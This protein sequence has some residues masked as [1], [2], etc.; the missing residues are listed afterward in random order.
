VNNSLWIANYAGTNVRDYSLAG[1]LLSSFVANAGVYGLA[2]DYSDNTLW[3][4]NQGTLYQYDRTGTQLSTFADGL[5]L[6]TLGAEFQFSAAS[7]PEPGTA[8][9][10]IAGLALLVF[11]KRRIRARK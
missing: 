4:D 2:M 9:L 5:S 10:G 8:Y 3:A 7:V 6:N 1:T 11:A